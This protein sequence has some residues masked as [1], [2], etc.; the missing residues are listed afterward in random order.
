MGLVA[1]FGFAAHLVFFT[2]PGL[3]LAALLIFKKKRSPLFW[4]ITALFVLT[5]AALRIYL[6][7]L[8][9]LDSGKAPVW[10]VF[11]S[12]LISKPLFYSYIPLI[13]FLLAGI[14]LSRL[15]RE[16]ALLA[17][18]GT[19]ILLSFPAQLIFVLLLNRY[20]L[21]WLGLQLSY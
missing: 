9:C 4:I 2:G 19:G 1:I 14:I 16:S 7:Y 21:S 10:Q 15:K 11:F 13:L 18:A 12:M 5:A 8:P 3:V 6:V 17:A 20:F